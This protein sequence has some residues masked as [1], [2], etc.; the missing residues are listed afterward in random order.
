MAPV[1]EQLT[2][3]RVD[4]GKGAGPGPGVDC[5]TVDQLGRVGA[6]A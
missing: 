1:L 3:L 4:G 5:Q 2:P 6:E